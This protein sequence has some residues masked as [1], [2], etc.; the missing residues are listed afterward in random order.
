MTRFAVAMGFAAAAAAVAFQEPRAVTLRPADAT[1]GEPF[2]SVYSIR[3]LADGRVLISDNGQDNRLVVADLASGRVRTVGNVGAGPGEYRAAGRLF[4][5]TGDSTLFIDSP[6]GGYW[7]LLLHRDS[8]VRNF[9]PDFPTLRV[10]GGRAAG[11][12]AGG[13]VL[14][15]RQAGSEKLAHDKVRLREITVLGDRNSSRADTLTTLTGSE[16]RIVQG[17][18]R[19]RPFWGQFQLSG[20]APEQAVLFPDD[21]IAFVRLNPYRV[22]WRTPASAMVRGPEVP[23]RAPRVDAKEKKAAYEILKR[24]VGDRAKMVDD[25]RWADRLSPIWAGSALIPSTNGHL[26]VLRA[27]WSQAMGTDYDIFDRT[28]RRIAT[29]ALPDSERVVGFGSRSIYVSVRDGD[30]FHYLRRHPWP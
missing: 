20:S 27:Q 18:T 25:S 21:W 24:R 30:G 3:E 26:L 10:V 13:L 7:W 19:E 4:A 5:L 12:G 28:G 6:Q 1:L 23:W 2:T 9:P 14:G 17:G 11:A 16:F 8:I 29:L 22:E 15:I